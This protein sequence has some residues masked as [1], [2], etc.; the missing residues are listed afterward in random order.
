MRV[1]DRGGWCPRR[2]GHLAEG[3]SGGLAYVLDLIRTGSTRRVD[4]EPVSRTSRALRGSSAANAGDRLA[5][6]PPCSP[7]GRPRSAACRD[8]PRDYKRVL[9]AYPARERRPLSRRGDHGS[10]PQMTIRVPRGPRG[11]SRDT[12]FLVG[13]LG[14]GQLGPDH[15]S[16]AWR[17][18]GGEVRT[19][20]RVAAAAHHLLRQPCRQPAA[21]SDERR[22]DGHPLRRAGRRG[23]SAA[24]V[25]ARSSATAGG[26]RQPPASS[27]HR[28]SS[29]RGSPPR[30]AAS[31]A[32]PVPPGTGERP[33]DGAARSVEKGRRC[34]RPRALPSAPTAPD[35]GGRGRTPRAAAWDCGW[36][37]RQAYGSTGSS[38]VKVGYESGRTQQPGLAAN[39]TPRCRATSPATFGQRRAVA[40]SR[41]GR[42]RRSDDNVTAR[43]SP[44]S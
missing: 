30:S 31:P 21:G 4:V 10:G 3:M 14:R 8:R 42:T 43:T 2:A 25:G 28:R 27:G 7:T 40:S 1:H 44:A 5:A 12:A 13:H 16:N 26:C 37:K 41:D 18:Q 36:S 17:R 22:G 24:Q 15:R 33:A 6:P 23:E 32:S 9:E 29:G 34:R 20:P 19:D 11:R 35:P 39:S 38:R